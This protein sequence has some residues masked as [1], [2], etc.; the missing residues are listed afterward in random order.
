MSFDFK[1]THVDLLRHGQVAT[2]GLFCA[3]AQEPLSTEG[4]NQLKQATQNGQWDVVITSPFRRCH[5]FAKTIKQRLGCEFVVEPRFQEMDFGDWMGQKQSWIWEHDAEHLSK[6]WQ[7]PRSFVAP[8]GESMENFSLRVHDAWS[9]L[10]TVYAGERV[11]VVTHAGVMRVLLGKTLD[12]L[13][14]KTLRFNIPHASFTRISA[15][16]DG[17]CSLEAHGVK[18]V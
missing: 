10:Q 18:Y 5:D 17:E 1:T 13:Y 14:A 12:I 9:D 7:Q 4:W 8:N 2:Q 3:T 6:L 15:Y 16:E 11:L